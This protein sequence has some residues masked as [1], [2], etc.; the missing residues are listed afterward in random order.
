ML[1]YHTQYVINEQMKTNEGDEED[2]QSDDE[3]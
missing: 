3:I 2:A 1:F